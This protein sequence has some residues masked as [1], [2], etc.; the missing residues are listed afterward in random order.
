MQ[1]TFSPCPIIPH[2]RAP[3]HHRKCGHPPIR[4]WLRRRPSPP[5][6]SH[7]PRFPQPRIRHNQQHAAGRPASGRDRR[8]RSGCR[9]HRLLE[10]AQ[11][12]HAVAADAHPRCARSCSRARPG[13]GR[14]AA[15]SGRRS[16]RR[17]RACRCSLRGRPGRI[18]CRLAIGR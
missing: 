15:I 3:M 5:N 8:D 13:I 1:L 17:W 16:R 7:A 12:V 4:M 6:P 2:P 9:Q 10:S 14:T 11:R 18:F